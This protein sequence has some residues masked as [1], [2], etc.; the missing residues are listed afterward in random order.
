MARV[1]TGEAELLNAEATYQVDGYSGIAWSYAG[2]EVEPGE[3]TEWTGIEEPTG[4]VVMVM[5]GDDRRFT[6]DP[7][8]CH[9]IA[10][11]DYCAE[12]GQ[13]GCTADGRAH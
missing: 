4:R 8:E 3:D 5:V 13:I 1:H 6:F 2:D 10:E 12:C 7:D 9:E 11:E